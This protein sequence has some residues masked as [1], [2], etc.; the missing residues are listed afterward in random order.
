MESGRK[1]NEMANPS[2]AYVL[3]K[4]NQAADYKNLFEQAFGRGPS[5]ETVG[6]ALASYQR[7]LNSANSAFDRWY[8]G[9]D[10]QALNK[11]AQLGLQLFKGKA[12]CSACH[13][14]DEKTALFTDNKTHNTGIGY[15]ESMAKTPAK[16]RIQVAP[17][18]FLDVDTE[19]I[20]SVAE[21]KPN[22]LGRY[23]ITQN[24]KHRWHY[25]TPSLRN[26]SLTKPY[27]HNGS[28]ATLKDVVDFY[29]R[30]GAQ[31]ENLDPLIK[32]LHLTEPEI[33]QLVVF[34]QALTGDNVSELVSDA[35]AAPVGDML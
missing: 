30:G 19:A 15:T 13:S 28:L 33:E 6:M 31:N 29:N 20:N 27:M 17:G 11:T 1:K 3:D 14:I 4:I 7:T 9:K 5:M 12:G 8:Y 25:R 24:P 34:L 21:N 26:V 10:T 23:E 32:P 16:Q 35:Y 22:D 18:V 2:I